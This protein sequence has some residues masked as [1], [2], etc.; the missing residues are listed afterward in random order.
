MVSKTLK[1]VLATFAL[2]WSAV[3]CMPAIGLTENLF[4]MDNTP[5]IGLHFSWGYLGVTGSKN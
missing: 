1:L 5:D 3:C 4:N 2:T